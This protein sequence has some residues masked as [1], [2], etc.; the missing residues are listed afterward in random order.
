MVFG[1]RLELTAL[2]ALVVPNGVLSL[3]TAGERAA[4][5]I[6]RDLLGVEVLRTAENVVVIPDLAELGTAVVER[7]LAGLGLVV[8]RTGAANVGLL[9]AE[10]GGQGVVDVGESVLGLVGGDNGGVREPLVGGQGAVVGDDGLEVV[11][12][13]ILL[14]VVGTL[15]KTWLD[16]MDALNQVSTRKTYVALGLE[17]REAGGVLGVLVSPEVPVGL[18]AADPVLVHVGKQIQ[19]ASGLKPVLDGLALVGR[20]GGTI[21]LGVGSVG[22]GNGVVLAAS[23][24][25]C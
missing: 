1:Q 20:D 14:L 22:R 13:I 15:L 18:A 25:A 10:A 12:Q 3:G 9:T 16:N 6:G 4:N 17:G 24:R 21:R 2:G 7:A 8:A 23:K 19:L 11:E 5:D